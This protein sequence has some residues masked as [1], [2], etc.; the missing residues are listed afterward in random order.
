MN[1]NAFLV[2]VGCTGNDAACLRALP[3][4]KIV[5]V[6]TDGEYPHDDSWNACRWAPTVDMVDLSETPAAVLKAGRMLLVFV[7]AIG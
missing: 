3:V 4:A 7:R 5:E 6:S 1:Y 2:R